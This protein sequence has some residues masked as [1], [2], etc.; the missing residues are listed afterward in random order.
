MTEKK[1]IPPFRLVAEPLNED[2]EKMPKFKWASN[3]IGARHKLG[4][5]PDFVQQE[6]RPCCPSCDNEMVFYAQ[7]DSI[8]DDYVIADCGMVYIFLCF[9]C[10]EIISFI[11][12][13]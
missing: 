3:S 12:S 1:I 6:R 11:Q 7:I 2:A 8:N 4:G 10:I 13:S 9:E 5:N